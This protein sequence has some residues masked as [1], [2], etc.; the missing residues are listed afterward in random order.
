MRKGNSLLYPLILAEGYCCTGGY[1]RLCALRGESRKNMAKW[2]GVSCRTIRR[3]YHQMQLGEHPC[4]RREECLGK[5][6]PELLTSSLPSNNLV[7]PEDIDL[8]DGEDGSQD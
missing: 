7:S 1:L 3:N 6:F 2:I 4:M 8:K 5:Q